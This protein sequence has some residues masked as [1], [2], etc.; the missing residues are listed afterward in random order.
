MT[1]QLPLV[2]LFATLRFRYVCCSRGLLSICLIIVTLQPR[3]YNATQARIT[4][5]PDEDI[6]DSWWNFSW[7]EHSPFVYLQ[8]VYDDGSLASATYWSFAIGP[9]TN[10]YNLSV[11]GYDGKISGDAFDKDAGSTIYA[12]NG[13]QFSTYES[14]HDNY[15][16]GNCASKRSSGW[17]FNHC[18]TSFLNTD[19]KGSWLPSRDFHVVSSRMAISLI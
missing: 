12:S 3:G 7:I 10:N 8:V 4:D 11:S 16:A 15:A 18:S 14:D 19:A 9:E 6:I 1:F 17:W 13:Q 2:Q 5:R